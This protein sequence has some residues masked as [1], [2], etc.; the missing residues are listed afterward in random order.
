[1]CEELPRFSTLMEGDLYIAGLRLSEQFVDSDGRRAYE[2]T[3]TSAG[4]YAG[5]TVA[6]SLAG[7]ELELHLVCPT[8]WSPVALAD[9]VWTFP[10]P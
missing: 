6:F 8:F 9:Q 1:M 4:K 5:P 3:L 2:A 10:A 7:D